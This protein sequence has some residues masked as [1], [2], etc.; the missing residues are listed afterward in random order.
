MNPGEHVER[1]K[2]RRGVAVGEESAAGE[3]CDGGVAG[4]LVE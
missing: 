3:E 4:L 2:G 1:G